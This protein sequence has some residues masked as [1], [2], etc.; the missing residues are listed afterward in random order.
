MNCGETERGLFGTM[1]IHLIFLL[2]STIMVYV[3]FVRKV[4]SCLRERERSFFS[5]IRRAM[6]M[7]FLYIK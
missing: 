3:C 2:I 6:L 1:E 5:M 7:G 4:P